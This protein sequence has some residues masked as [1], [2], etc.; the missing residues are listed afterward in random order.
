MINESLISFAL[1]AFPFSPLLL[2]RFFVF[3]S[4]YF[5]LFVMLSLSYSII[6][7]LHIPFFVLKLFFFPYIVTVQIFVFVFISSRY[8]HIF[9]F[10]LICHA[11]YYL[12]IITIRF[13]SSSFFSVF[14]SPSSSVPLIYFLCTIRPLLC[15]IHSQLSVV[16]ISQCHSVIL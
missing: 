10:L 9:V 5:F 6:R 16:L 2:C 1:Y 3:S 14:L 12:R 13:S 7:L 11:S 8:L 4:V 15:C